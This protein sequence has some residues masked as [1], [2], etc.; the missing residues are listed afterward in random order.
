MDGDSSHFTKI[1][2]NLTAGTSKD[3]ALKAMGASAKQEG[4]QI[5]LYCPKNTHY[6]Y[7]TISNDKVTASGSV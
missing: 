5:R 7:A 4:D 6:V 1:L 2:A 3:D